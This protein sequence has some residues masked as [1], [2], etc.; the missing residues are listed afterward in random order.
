[1][2][3]NRLRTAWYLL[4]YFGPRWVYFRSWYAVKQRSGWLQKQ[5]PVSTWEAQRL[6]QLLDDARLVNPEA[7]LCYRRESSL[8]FFF[9]PAQRLTFLPLLTA[10]DELETPP[11]QYAEYIRRG[12]LRYFEHTLAHTGCP[13]TWHTNPFTHQQAPADRHWSHISDFGYG[14]IKVIWEASRF[15]FVY[16][17]V[18]TYWRTGE[19]WC[20][21]LFWQLVE[22]WRAQNPP[23]QGPHWKCGQETSLRVMAWCF[24]LYG[25]LDSQVTT[26]ARVAML[27]QMIAVSGQRIAANLDYALSQRNN[28]GIS[29]GMGLWTIGTL[30]PELHPAAQWRQLGY[31]VLETQGRELIYDDGS[32]AQHSVNYQRLMLHDYVWSIR[33]GDL[34]GQP[35]SPA[36]RTRVGKAGALLY[37]IQDEVSGRVPY[38]GQNDGALILPLTNCDYHDFRPIIQAIHYLTTGTRCYAAGPWDEEL[39]WLFGPESLAAPV[40]S[41]VREDL[42]ADGGGYYTLRTAHG[43]VFTRCTTF[44]HRPSQADMLHLDLW[45]RGHNIALD[46]GTYSYNAPEPWDNVFAQTAYH[47]TVTVDDLDQMQRVSPFL[48]LP[49]SRGRVRTAQRSPEGQLAYWEGEHDGY[50]RCRPQVCHR[51]GI[52]RLGDEHWL[53]LDALH[54]RGKYRYRLHWLL[55]DVPHEWDAEQGRLTLNLSGCPYQVQLAASSDCGSHSLVRAD[56]HSPRG[57]RAPYYSYREPALS[58]DMIR[59]TDAV[60]F[61]TLFG[62]APYRAEMHTAALCI[63]TDRWQACVNLRRD[64]RTALLAEASISGAPTDILRISR[65]VSC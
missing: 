5:L 7:Y 36:L 40:S 16:A 26:A 41:P 65:C 62:P 48:W 32:F 18:R 3:N 53:V 50:Q 42:R 44:R 37:Q 33:L 23:Q 15:G 61:W 8:A 4:R 14:D 60:C 52:L 64:S 43:F 63:M 59:T 54:S 17:L 51:R 11:G 30:F 21:E 34:C 56:A 29:E 10:W 45:W 27:A 28:H 46:A 1:M 57:W 19:P 58:V 24:G 38:Y 22:D 35:F 55:P 20:A 9:T 13:P 31:Q 49:W 25:F 2:H 12:E 6:Q 39:L 47:N